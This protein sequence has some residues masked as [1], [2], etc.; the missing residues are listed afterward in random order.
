MKILC[1]YANSNRFIAPVPVGLSLVAQNALDNGHDIQ[2]LD[3]MWLK[4]RDKMLLE[5]LNSYRPDLVAFSLRNIDN[6]IMRDMQWYVLD[7]KRWI[8]IAQNYSPTVV[9][10]TAF[11]SYPKELMY[12][13]RPTYGFAGHAHTTFS[14]FLKELETKKTQFDTP[15][16]YWWQDKKVRYNDA[17]FCDFS[18]NG[19]IN[20]NLIDKEKYFNA[21][22]PSAIILKNGCPLNCIFCDVHR[23][24]GR[25]FSYRDPDEIVYE[26]KENNEKWKLSRY[27][28]KFIDNI[29]N[30]PLDWAKTLLEKIIRSGLKIGFSA[31][32][33]PHKYDEE[34]FN[35]LK[36]AGCLMMSKMLVSASD[37]VLH[38]NK[39][40]CTKSRIEKFLLLCE[41]YKIPFN[42][43][44]VF[45]SPGE[46]HRTIEETIK[47]FSKFKFMMLITELG[48][49]IHRNTDLYAIALEKGQITSQSD[50]L[51]PEFY[52]EP[53]VDPYWVYQR[54]I[55]QRRRQKKAYNKWLRLIWNTYR[56]RFQ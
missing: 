37:K 26:L 56:L 23:T 17:I 29:F 39:S 21:R 49:R 2:M 51:F 5:C 38:K 7:Y 13:L 50:L 48:L 25:R 14:D 55:A 40:K 3:F 8:S 27:C 32:V 53:G 16:I 43:I 1:V 35:L 36:Q 42:P 10:G 30:E 15:G 33:Y 22:M 24:S 52:I 46:T 34:F 44:V 28:Y 11:T 20:W 47:F 18:E 9:G 45:G 4:D 54:Q 19:R 41:K 31:T 6:Q 12:L